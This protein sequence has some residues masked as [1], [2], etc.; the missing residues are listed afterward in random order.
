[1]KFV[2]SARRVLGLI[3]RRAV[4]PPG[5]KPRQ[6]AKIVRGD[7]RITVQAGLT[8]NTWGW[9]AAEGWREVTYPD[10]RRNYRDVPS[11][12]VAELFDASDPDQLRQR[13]EVA[14]SEAI[15]RPHISLGRRR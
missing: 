3:K 11:S 1:M 7:L 13:L 10:D 8:E 14:A 12:R 9:L 6:G 15:Q 4:P 2:Y 5:P